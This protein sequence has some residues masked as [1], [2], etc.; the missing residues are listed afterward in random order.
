MKTILIV[1]ILLLAALASV[2][3]A[4]E[5]HNCAEHPTGMEFGQHV[6]GHAKDMELGKDHNP[7]MHRGFSP[8][9][10]RGEL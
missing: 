4:H 9:V 10:H 6:A 5:E 8:C 7:G 1:S 2:A 3:S